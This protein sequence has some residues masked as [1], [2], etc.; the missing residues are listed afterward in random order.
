MGLFSNIKQATDV[1]QT[2]DRV[3]GSFKP[4]TSGVY[5][6]II[7]QMYAKPAQSG[8]IGVTIE[9]EVQPQQDKP[10]KFTE[11]YYVTNKNGENFFTDKAGNKQYL[12]GFNHVNDLCLGLTQKT[13]FELE[14]EGKIEPKNIKVYNY[15]TKKDEIEQ[16]PTFVPLLEKTVALGLIERRENKTTKSGNEYV[17]TA[18]ERVYNTLDKV[19]LLKDNQPFTHNE[20]KAGLNEPK[21]VQQ[22]LDNWKDKVDDRYKEVEG[23]S[24]NGSSQST[25][26]LTL[27]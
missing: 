20:L 10:R 5:S 8:A 16:L 26:E 23:S 3:G 12:P 11:T 15:T 24:S 9:F 21:F 1:K 2:E 18:E 7:K 6:A 19:F 4:L 25:S 22:W 17:A 13:M 14:A 27:G